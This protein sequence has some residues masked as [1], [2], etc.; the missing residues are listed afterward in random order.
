MSVLSWNGHW[1]CFYY[2]FDPFFVVFGGSDTSYGVFF[3]LIFL[4]GCCFVCLFFLGEE[5]SI[6][7]L[8][9]SNG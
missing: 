2:F 9:Y 4:V 3:S 7:E 8:E 6:F 5:A 1:L